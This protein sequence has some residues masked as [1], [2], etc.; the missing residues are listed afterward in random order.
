LDAFGRLY[1]WT[2]YAID[3]N[4][5][6]TEKSAFAK[7]A[8]L[9]QAAFDELKD[10]VPEPKTPGDVSAFREKLLRDLVYNTTSATVTFG[11]YL[12]L[13]CTPEEFAPPTNPFETPFAKWKKPVL[14]HE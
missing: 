4:V 14:D 6:D 12:F 8:T 5:P 2:Q 3:K 9:L 10:E 1:V 7:T 13:I 11:V